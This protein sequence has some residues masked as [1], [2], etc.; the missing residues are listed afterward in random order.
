MKLFVNRNLSKD[1]ECWK[2]EVLKF[3]P[4]LTVYNKLGKKIKANEAINCDVHC[5]IPFHGPRT[6]KISIIPENKKSDD[7]IGLFLMN[8]P[9]PY[10]YRMLARPDDPLDLSAKYKNY[11]IFCDS[12]EGK[13]PDD[14]GKF[15]CSK[16]GIYRLGTCIVTQEKELK[17]WELTESGWK[18]SETKPSKYSNYLLM[19]DNLAGKARIDEALAAIAKI[20]SSFNKEVNFTVSDII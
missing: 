8:S 19:D 17:Y 9:N 1:V 15:R 20:S 4:V 13:G 2:C 10:G 12:I 5:K 6:S 11:R 3:F 7:I 14:S 16:F 18:V